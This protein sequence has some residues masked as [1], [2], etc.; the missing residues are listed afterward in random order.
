LLRPAWRFLGR[1]GLAERKLLTLLLWRPVRF[2]I[3]PWW[4]LYRRYLHRP[5]VRFLRALLRSPFWLLRE[6]ARGAGWL[7]VRP[8]RLLAESARKRWRVGYTRRA[9]WRREQRSRV[10][11]WQARMRVATSRPQPPRR[12]IVAPPVPRL[13]MS[14]PRRRRTITRLATTGLA[15]SLVAVASFITAQEAPRLRGAAAENEY[16]ISS[17]KFVTVTATRPA[18]TVTPTIPASPTPAP[19]ADP[20]NGGGSVVFTMRQEGN[21]DLYSLSIGQSQPVRL[22]GD[23]ADDRDPAWSPDGK[24]IA[25]A[26][27]RDGNWEIYVLRLKD[28]SV[29][30]MTHDPAFD[31][32]PGWS[33]DGQWLV[34]E[35]YRAGSLDLYL[36]S[37]DGEQG[38]I[39]LTQHPAPD[40]SPVWSPGGRHIAFTSWR[41]GNKDIY[42]LSLDDAADEN[43]YN[44]T[45]T[46]GQFEDNP[47][48]SPDGSRLAYDEDSSGRHFVYSLPLANYVGAGSPVSHGQ[49]QHPTWSPDGRALTYIYSSGNQYHLTTGRLDAWSVSP[50]TFSTPAGLDQPNWS[51]RSLPRPLPEALQ[52]IDEAVASPLLREPVSGQAEGQPPYLLHELPVNAPAPY[53]SDRVDQSFLLLRERVQ[54]ETGWDFLGELDQMYEAIGARALPGQSNQTWNK[55]GRA[56]DYLSDHALSFD[57]IIEVVRERR[58]ASTYWRTYLKTTAQD[59]T[60][61]EPLREMPWDFRARFGPESRYYDEGGRTKEQIPAGYYVDFTALAAD[62]GWTW[63][64]TSDN[65]RTYFPG[66]RYWHYENQQG[67]TWEQAMLE[68]YTADEILSVFQR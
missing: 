41:S 14:A 31:G 47:A 38:P 9:C 57:P 43:A 30:R 13:T 34:F 46:P 55:A 7:F 23:P 44:V 18:P 8:V 48:F 54:T 6:G 2:M 1:L 26:S 24:E 37:A 53:L 67:L 66:I 63:S 51:V 52:S 42:M 40:Y 17:S 29:R 3:R 27:R 28:G 59:G 65:W 56:F 32:G 25:F 16:Q 39:R 64:P 22:T 20:L 15:V 49:G 21:S 19:T 45:N 35:S 58:E 61:G 33:P 60:Q 10:R 36:L 12:A 5:L 11:V 68:L 50:Q 62:Y 4:L